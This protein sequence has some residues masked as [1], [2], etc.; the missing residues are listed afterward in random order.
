MGGVIDLQASVGRVWDG[1]VRP[2]VDEAVRCYNSG[3]A[4]AAIATTWTAV[5]ADVLSKISHLA[6]GQDPA[7]AAFQADVDKARGHGLNA[8]GVRAMQAI[9]DRLLGAALELELIDNIG[10]RELE[11]IRQDRHLCV[12][13]SLRH[14]GLTYQPEA[15]VARAHLAVALS[16]LLLHAPI[17]GKKIQESFISYICDPAFSPAPT[18][19]QATYYDRVRAGARRRMVSLAAKHALRELP[20]P[21]ETGVGARVVADRMAVALNAFADRDRDQV[22]EALQEQMGQFATLNGEAHCGTG[23]A[24]GTRHVVHESRPAARLEQ[25]DRHGTA[26]SGEQDVVLGKLD[27]SLPRRTTGATRAR[28]SASRVAAPAASDRLVAAGAGEVERHH[29]EHQPGGVRGEH[30]GRQVRQR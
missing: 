29:R 6:E 30:P 24:N 2:L 1:D 25:G 10:Q 3:A 23:P 27:W 20:V 12:H 19:V 15:E 9:E 4:R 7:A 13:P 8:E 28:G 18:H 26:Y 22:C 17:Q 21:P 16:T 11:R 5:V 14:L